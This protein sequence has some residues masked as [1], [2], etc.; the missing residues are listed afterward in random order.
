[1]EFV[2]AINHLNHFI[3][4]W[5]RTEWVTRRTENVGPAVR[6]LAV[7]L[8]PQ[9]GCHVDGPPCH[10]DGDPP[11]RRDAACRSNARGRSEGSQTGGAGD[12]Q[13]PTIAFARTP[14]NSKNRENRDDL[15]N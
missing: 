8:G 14:I 15:T 6:I 3:E 5:P 1:M 2:T 12:S 11:R 9:V 10:V 7:T 4:I 13:T